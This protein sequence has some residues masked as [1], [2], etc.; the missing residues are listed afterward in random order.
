[1][2]ITKCGT[3]QLLSKVTP[4]ALVFYKC[5]VEWIQIEDFTYSLIVHAGMVYFISFVE[6]IQIDDFTYLLCG[7][8]SI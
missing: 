5:F 8:W 3:G 6:W 2:V 7:G 4:V 1:M